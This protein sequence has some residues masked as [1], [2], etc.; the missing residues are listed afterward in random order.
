[1]HGY[2]INLIIV[3]QRIKKLFKEFCRYKQIVPTAPKKELLIVFH[4]YEIFL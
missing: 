3:D 2:S 1:M 4:F